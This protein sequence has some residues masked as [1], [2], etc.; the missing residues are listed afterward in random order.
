M[1]DRYLREGRESD[2]LVFQLLFTIFQNDFL[3]P[4][5]FRLLLQNI[6]SKEEKQHGGEM[7]FVC[8]IRIEALHVRALLPVKT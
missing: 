1:A 8:P 4:M 6:G 3:R 7:M 2:R 5:Q